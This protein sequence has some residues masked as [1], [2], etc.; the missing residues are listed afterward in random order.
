MDIILKLAL[1]SVI[2]ERKKKGF[3]MW[4]NY[5]S[6]HGLTPMPK[7]GRRERQRQRDLPSEDSLTLS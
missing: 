7:D 6:P 5:M 4:T 1:T 2:K 3:L